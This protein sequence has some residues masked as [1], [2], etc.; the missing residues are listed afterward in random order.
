MDG[1]YKISEKCNTYVNS[2]TKLLLHCS[3]T[4]C[5]KYWYRILNIFTKRLDPV[6]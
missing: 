2:L 3:K 5:S 1:C 4:H 6:D